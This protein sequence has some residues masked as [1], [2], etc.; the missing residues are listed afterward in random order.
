MEHDDFLMRRD[1]TLRM[2]KSQLD[3]L[4]AGDYEL[5]LV[6]FEIQATSPDKG[7]FNVEI[8]LNWNPHLSAE[9]SDGKK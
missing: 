3:T 6:G 2:L 7:A 9:E 8:A 4:F 1:E 5:L